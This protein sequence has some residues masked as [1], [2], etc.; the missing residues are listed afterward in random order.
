MPW[1][2]KWRAGTFFSIPLEGGVFGVGRTLRAPYASFYG[3]FDSLPGVEQLDGLEPAFTIA[4]MRSAFRGSGSSVLGWVEPTAQ[5]QQLFVF[6]HQDA[7]SGKYVRRI[8]T[9]EVPWQEVPANW[10]E[11]KDLE[12]DAVWSAEHVEE[13]LLAMHQGR[14]SVYLESL[15][16]TPP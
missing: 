13:R 7:I 5:V 9:E 3:V 8:S 10:N 1:P 2:R 16:P 4:V 11:V 12:P 15:R 6:G 14:Q